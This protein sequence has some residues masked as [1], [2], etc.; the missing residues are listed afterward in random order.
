MKKYF[1]LMA[2]VAIAGMVFVSCGDDDDNGGGN[3]TANV[4][5]PIPPTKDLARDFSFVKGIE[6]DKLTIEDLQKSPMVKKGVTISID[7]DGIIGGPKDPKNFI[8][9]DIKVTEDRKV[10]I[11]YIECP[12]ELIPSQAPT[13]GGGID[14]NSLKKIYK[15]HDFT[16]NGDEYA[17]TGFGKMVVKTSSNNTATIDLIPDGINIFNVVVDVIFPFFNNEMTDYLCRTWTI[18][19]Y[20]IL[21]TKNGLQVGNALQSSDGKC[22]LQALIDYANNEHGAGIG[23]VKG[24]KRIVNGITFTSY[25]TF[26]INYQNTEDKD[27]GYWAWSATDTNQKTGTIGY[28]WYDKEEMGNDILAGTATVAFRGNECDLRLQAKVDLKYKVEVQFKLK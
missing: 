9:T 13:R 22:D 18:S 17:I 23:P 5:L 14:I 6:M 11:Q 10:L 20:R 7:E 16:K 3:G 21:V 25:K 24:N 27:V 19:A 15:F 26:L 12:D 28:A 2:L 8:I 1:Y 4:T